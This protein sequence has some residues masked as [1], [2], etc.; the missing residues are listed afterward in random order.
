M[1]LLERLEALRVEQKL[2][3]AE[4]RKQHHKVLRELVVSAIN[5]AHE[6][7]HTLTSWNYTSSGLIS[8]CDRCIAGVSVT[9]GMDSMPCDPEGY[10]LEW[11]CSAP[12][13][14]FVDARDIQAG[15]SKQ[16]DGTDGR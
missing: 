2:E 7:G 13:Y 11:P 10:A 3:R 5:Q 8:S 14:K 6:L 4:R 12:L 15:R 16:P 9:L 1:A